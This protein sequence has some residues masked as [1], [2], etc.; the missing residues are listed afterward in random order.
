MA[1][2]KYGGGIV[3]MSG[4]I[5]GTTFARNR[6]GNYARAKTMPI[7]PNTAL[8]I[9][10]RTTLAFLTNEWAQ[11]LTAIQRTAWNLYGSSVAMKNRLGE[12]VFLTGF[13]H[14]IRSNSLLKRSGLTLVDD[15]P[16]VFEIPASD[17]TLALTGTATTQ[18]ITLVYDDQMTWPDENG[19]F[20]FIFL[21]QPQNA[22]RN[23]FDGPWRLTDFVTGIN[24]APPTS[25]TVSTAPFAISEGQHLWAYARIM[26]ADGRLSE[27]FRA[28]TFCQA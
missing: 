18:D 13:N 1:L 26:R 10:V 11:T 16:V 28:D 12:A 7:N 25:P 27:A 3:Q 24:G 17:P 23:F 21:G 9:V 14:Y 20:L 8:Q 6:Y 4:S 15:G 2:I 22:Q 19:G 5:G